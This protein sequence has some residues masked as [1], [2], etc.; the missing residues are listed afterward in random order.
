MGGHPID[1][2]CSAR[3]R[4]LA[5]FFFFFFFFNAMAIWM[6]NF[7]TTSRFFAFGKGRG[8]GGYFVRHVSGIYKS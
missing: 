1:V 6:T 5:F 4:W 2:K 8:V 3:R 7:S